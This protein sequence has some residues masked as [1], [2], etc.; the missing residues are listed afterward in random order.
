MN[1]A[2]LPAARRHERSIA[3]AGPAGGSSRWW[4][5]REKKSRVVIERGAQPHCYHRP[6]TPSSSTSWETQDPVHQITIIPVAAGGTPSPLPQED[7]LPFP[8]GSS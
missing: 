5:V 8:V 2:A 4:P 7:V 6:V 3:G 1:E